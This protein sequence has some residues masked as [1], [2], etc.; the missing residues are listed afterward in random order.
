MVARQQQEQERLIGTVAH[1]SNEME[2]NKEH[3]KVDILPF[4]GV[5]DLFALLPT[6]YHVPHYIHTLNPLSNVANG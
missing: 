1:V 6:S 2:I 4:L 5:V 3:V